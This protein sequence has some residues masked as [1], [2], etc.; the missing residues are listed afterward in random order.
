MHYIQFLFT[1]YVF[2]IAQWI[3]PNANC[4]CKGKR[5]FSAFNKFAILDFFLMQLLASNQKNEQ[6]INFYLTKNAIF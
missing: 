4:Y 5:D 1:S 2:A 6:I 3:F